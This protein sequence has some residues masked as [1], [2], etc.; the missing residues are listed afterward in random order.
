MRVLW[1]AILV[2][3]MVFVSIG[4]ARAQFVG[5]PKPAPIVVT[6]T[7]S[8]Q[9]MVIAVNGQPRFKWWVSTGARGH[10]TPS[11]QYKVSWLDEHHK[12]KQY[13]GG[14]RAFC[15]AVAAAPAPPLVQHHRN[16]GVTRH[17]LH[18]ENA[19]RKCN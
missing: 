3:A 16:R 17:G 11:G 4:T 6:V 2:V 10:A 8:D 9:R 12:S 7:K 13:N 19:L 14:L 5:V 18:C 1:A 15:A